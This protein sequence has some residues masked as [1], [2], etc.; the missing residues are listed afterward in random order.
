VSFVIDRIIMRGKIFIGLILILLGSSF[1][2]QTLQIVDGMIIFSY[3]FPSILVIAG[4][5]QLLQKG[6]SKLSGVIMMAV[7]VSLIL[8]NMGVIQEVFFSYLWPF[9]IILSGLW[10]IF[11]KSQSAPSAIS[12]DN[13]SISA[14]FGGVTQ[15]IVSSNFVSGSVSAFFGGCDIDL[16]EAELAQSNFGYLNVIAM[17]GGIKLFVPKD[18]A[19]EI[20]ATPIFGGI[21]NKTS[22]DLDPSVDQKILKLEGIVIFGGVEICN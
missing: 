15:K 13:I 3:F 10:I 5:L 20:T 19:I 11:S 1:L 9:L 7:G 14:L 2:L 22:T 21:E 6:V 4:G 16:R 18:W 8:L 12:Q 17:F